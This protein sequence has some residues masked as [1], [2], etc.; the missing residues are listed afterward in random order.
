MADKETMKQALSKLV[1]DS[2]ANAVCSALA[3]R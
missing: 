1:E 3:G 2:G